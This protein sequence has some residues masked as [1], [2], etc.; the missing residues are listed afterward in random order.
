MNTAIQFW[1]FENAADKRGIILMRDI[2]GA[3]VTLYTGTIGTPTLAMI[4]RTIR[5]YIDAARL[6]G[7]AIEGETWGL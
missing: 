6:L 1:A 2:S 4:R 7:V 3:S 5:P